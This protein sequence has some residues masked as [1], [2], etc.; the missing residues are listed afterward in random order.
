VTPLAAKLAPT[1]APGRFDE[2]K[3]ADAIAVLHTLVL[4]VQDP[5]RLARVRTHLLAMIK[6]SRETLDA[7]ATETDNDREWLPGPAQ[8]SALGLTLSAE[9]A[10]GWRLVLTELEAL[11]EGKKLLPHWRFKDGRGFSV[12]RFL[13]DSRETDLVLLIQGT[14]A[15]PYLEE[16]PLSDAT[17]WRQITMLFRGN[18]LGYALWIN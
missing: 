11:L 8:Q 13:S 7:I 4:P 10:G 6:Y 3:I 14:A 5:A 18:F 12:K 16:G 15:V 17:T 2:G 9:Q 1:Q